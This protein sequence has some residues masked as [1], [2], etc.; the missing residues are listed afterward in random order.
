MRL[1]WIFEAASPRPAG[2]GEDAEGMDTTTAQEANAG[3][4]IVEHGTQLSG[5]RQ[6]L[7]REQDMPWLLAFTMLCGT[8]S[9]RHAGWRV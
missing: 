6:K 2:L 9:G 8:S 7:R 1:L 3:A 5:A 4:P